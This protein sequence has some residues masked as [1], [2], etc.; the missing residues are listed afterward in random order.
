ME[1]TKNKLVVET[2]DKL[3]DTDVLVT[4]TFKKS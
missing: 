2:P 4:I 1:F 3:D